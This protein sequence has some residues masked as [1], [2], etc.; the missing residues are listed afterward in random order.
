MVLRTLLIALAGAVAVGA[1]P[2]A[3]PTAP[4]VNET[5]VNGDFA[6]PLAV[7]WQKSARN[8]VGSNIVAIQKDG[9]VKVQKTMCGHARI[10]QDVKLA[11]LNTV[12]STRVKFASE[13]TRDDYYAYSTVALG[14]FDKSGKKLGET[15]WFSTTGTRPW[16]ASNTV[17]L[18]PIARRGEWQD[19]TLNI[20]DELRKNL[21][22]IV[23]GKVASLRI[24]LESYGSGTEAC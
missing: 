23:P 3:A 22:G 18:V 19:V 8:L 16:Q 7:G 14:Y 1:Q 11:A 21:A 15:R 20:G 2:A 12:F 13:A 9:G 24:T 4:V 10:E 17:R 6:Q 5:L